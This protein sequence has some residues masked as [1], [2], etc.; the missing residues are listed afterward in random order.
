MKSVPF[1]IGQQLTKPLGF[2]FKS[3]Q[4]EAREP[5]HTTDI[6]LIQATGSLSLVYN[7]APSQLISS[8]FKSS[9]P[10][11]VAQGVQNGSINGACSGC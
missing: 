3:R 8:T 9:I 6:I 11:R 5:E 10:V 4:V 2:G 7:L 1:A